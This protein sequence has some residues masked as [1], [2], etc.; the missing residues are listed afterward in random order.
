MG[1]TSGRGLGLT[2]MFCCTPTRYTRK[3]HALPACLHYAPPTLAAAI[4]RI[5]TVPRSLLFTALIYHGTYHTGR[6]LT[7]A[8]T[9]P[10]VTSFLSLLCTP[11]TGRRPTP[12][13]Y[14]LHYC[15]VV[16]RSH[17]TRLS[18]LCALLHPVSVS[19]I[20]TAYGFLFGCRCLS[21]AFLLC[22]RRHFLLFY[23]LF[24]AAY[25]LVSP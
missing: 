17:C 8:W 21:A 23:H 15:F 10:R 3:L 13:V 11:Q 7:W 24:F 20:T 4:R 14:S 19:L 1:G 9:F 12:A 5:H 22:L 6:T 25:V 16:I 18:V 2:P